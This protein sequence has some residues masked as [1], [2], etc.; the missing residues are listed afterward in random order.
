MATNYNPRFDPKP[1][2]RRRQSFA[3]GR[4]PMSS[5][6]GPATAAPPRPASRATSASSSK[7]T[8][9]AGKSAQD[10]VEEIKRLKCLIESDGLPLAWVEQKVNQYVQAQAKSHARMD[11]FERARSDVALQIQKARAAVEWHI[12][13]Q[14]QSTRDYGEAYYVLKSWEKQD[15]HL[16]SQQEE[17]QSQAESAHCIYLPYQ[18]MKDRH[19][20]LVKL[21]GQLKRAQQEESKQAQEKGKGKSPSAG[22]QRW[23]AG[24]YPIVHAPMPPGWS[25]KPSVAGSRTPSPST[26]RPP[27]RSGAQ[28]A[29]ASAIQ[30]PPRTAHSPSPAP[31]V[32][33]QTDPAEQRRKP[34]QQPRPRRASTSTADGM[35]RNFASVN[36]SKG[37]SGDEQPRKSS[38]GGS[39][40]GPKTNHY[41]SLYDADIKRVT[42][43]TKLALNGWEEKTIDYLINYLFKHYYSVFH[44]AGPDAWK[45][46]RIDFNN[47][48]VPSKELRRAQVQQLLNGLQS[49]SLRPIRRSM[50]LQRPADHRMPILGRIMPDLHH[51]Y[52]LTRT[53]RTDEGRSH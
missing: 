37:P 30:A 48:Y 4:P 53:R 24:G 8:A 17:L 12:A 3:G 40:R 5:W 32:R 27:S 9:S 22:E 41:G 35:T 15:D 33:R 38:P 7:T 19:T 49:V 43:D 52:H 6:N 14:L 34:P 23:W 1:N 13:R 2:E 39:A 16:R 28:S 10:L 50:L 26:V 45:R 11:D 36:L 51:L 44:Q 21:E 18:R 31:P 47:N 25:P 46:A 42:A 29:H 20:M